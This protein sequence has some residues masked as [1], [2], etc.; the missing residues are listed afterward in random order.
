V[1][2]AHR[3]YRLRLITALDELGKDTRLADLTPTRVLEFLTCDRVMRTKT[4]VAKA[5]PTFLKTQRVLRVA[6]AWAQ[7]ARLI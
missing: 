4:G 5:R 3:C 2:A 7:D 1:N 6:L